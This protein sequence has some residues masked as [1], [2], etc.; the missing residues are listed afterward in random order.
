MRRPVGNHRGHSEDGSGRS[1]L[2]EASMTELQRYLAEEVAEDHIDGHITRREAIRRLGM[3]GITGPAATAMLVMPAHAADKPPKPLFRRGSDVSEWTMP[4]TAPIAFP[5]PTATLLGAW[6]E[7][8]EPRGGV[9]VIHE[10]RGLNDHIRSIASRLATQ[11]YSALAIDLL[12]EEGGTDALPDDA[13]RQAALAAAPPE[14][15]DVDM[16]AAVSELKRRLPRKRLAAM[17]F[18]FGGA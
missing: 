9:L 5:G 18:C 12:S 2:E 16:Q 17:G 13:A 6:A 8:V 11:G 10:N 3:L 15:F 1:T 4:P 14:R 7:A